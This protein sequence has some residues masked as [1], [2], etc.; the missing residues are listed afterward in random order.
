M[1]SLTSDLWRSDHAESVRSEIWPGG[2][3]AANGEFV[4]ADAGTD[5]A[6]GAADARVRVDITPVEQIL[7]M[8]KTVALGRHRCPAD[9]PQF[10]RGGGPHTCAYIAFHRTSVRMKIDDWRAEVA[11]PNHVSFY[12]VGGS[13]SREAIGSEGDEC[14]WLAVSPSLLSTLHADLLPGEPVADDICSRGRSRRCARVLFAQRKLF[15]AADASA[16]LNSLEI[17]SRDQPDRPRRRRLG[18]TSGAT[19]AARASAAPG[20][21]APPPQIIKDAKDRRGRWTTCRS[22]TSPTSCTAR[23]RTCRASS[24]PRPASRCAIT[25]R[26]CACARACSCSRIP[27]VKSATSPCR[28]ASPATAI[29]PARSTGAS[30][31]SRRNS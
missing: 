14:D 28:S 21:P 15:A 26:S 31:R 22:P 18:S 24:T 7:R 10:M 9:H 13:Y 12:N 23:R 11:T 17:R 30:A 3:Q 29:S 19:R 2:R 1:H 20:V 6:D 27:V 5:D 25:A 8:T 4:H 16:S